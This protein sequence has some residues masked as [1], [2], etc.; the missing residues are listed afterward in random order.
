MNFTLFITIK[1]D[2]DVLF[3][4]NALQSSKRRNKHTPNITSFE[5]DVSTIEAAFIEFYDN[6][7]YCLIY[8]RKFL[9]AIWPH[10]LPQS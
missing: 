2:R 8:K 7:K 3:H 10:L 5:N 1:E 9:F 6:D 4:I